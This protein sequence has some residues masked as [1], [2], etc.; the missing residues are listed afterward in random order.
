MNLPSVRATRHRKD[1][2][3]KILQNE[4]ANNLTLKKK[5]KILDLASGPARYLVELIN[6]FNQEMIEVL[7][8]EEKKWFAEKVP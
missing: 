7:C 8:L 2:I 3:I 5:T 6:D 1:I 4:I